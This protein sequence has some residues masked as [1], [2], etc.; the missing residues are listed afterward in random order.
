MTTSGIDNLIGTTWRHKKKGAIYTVS[1][2]DQEQ[3]DVYLT[4][5]SKGCRSTWKW[6]SLLA[7]DY[8]RIEKE[9]G[10]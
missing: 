4:T 10:Q 5:K 8:E 3:G 7:Y 6:I 9:E 1:H 2:V